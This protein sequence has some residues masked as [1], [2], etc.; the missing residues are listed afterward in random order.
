MARAEDIPVNGPA[1]DRRWRL[2]LLVALVAVVTGFYWHVIKAPDQVILNSTGD[3]LKN[4]YTLLWQANN[5]TSLLRYSGSNYPFGESVFYT[6]GHPLL[7]WLLRPL[8]G[9]AAQGVGVLNLLLFLGLLACCQCLYLLLRELG[10]APW[11]AAIG[12]FCITLLQPQIFRL[13]GHFS[14]A[15][16][17]IIPLLML[18]SVRLHTAERWRRPWSWTI[19]V[20][21]IAYLT[22]AYMGFMGTMLLLAHGFSRYVLGAF[23][24]RALRAFLFRTLPAAILPMLVFL[25]L[26]RMSDTVADRPAD[27]MG[28]DRYATRFLSLIVPTHD[29]FETPLR[30]FF[31]Y[32]KLEWEAWCYLGLSP[33]LVLVA[34]GAVQLRRWSVKGPRTPV[35]GAGQLLMAGFLVLLFA[36][37]VWQDWLGGG[38]PVLDQFRSTGRFAWPFFYACAVFCVVRAYQWFVAGENVRK[39]VAIPVFIVVT[40]FMAVEGWAYHRDGSGALGQA[41]NPFRE[42]GINDDRRAL[43]AAIKGSGAAAIVPQPLV[44]FGSERYDTSAPEGILGLTLPLAYHAGVPMMA[45]FT[46]R[47][48]LG[49]TR[50]LFALLAPPYFPKTLR[51]YLPDS[52]RLLLIRQVGRTAPAEDAA[53]ARAR[54]LLEN[55]EG[56]IR[57]ITAGELLPDE[58]EERKRWYAALRDSLP[59][60]GPWRFS[61]RNHPAS[62]EAMA[63]VFHGPD[64]LSGRVNEWYD[65]IRVEPGQLD[66]ATMYELTFL[67]S[68]PHPRSVNVN[69]ILLHETAW[70]TE[71][72]WEDLRSVRGMPMQ[73]GD[74][75]AVASFAFRAEHPDRRYKFLF[76]GPEADSSV[77]MVRDVLLRPL[78]LDV[79]REGTWEG[80]PCVFLNG[81]PLNYEGGS[82]A[83]PSG[84]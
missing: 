58:R 1:A 63:H 84:N 28:V 13:G 27:P 83:P 72:K 55:A 62:Q 35:D 36:F 2:A 16:A 25:L 29:P 32:D 75:L 78:D 46:S 61:Q 7:G 71:G 70:G 79:W 53:W 54:P 77:Y 14:L 60:G 73:L 52:T 12:A 5:D 9:L 24:R 11:A 56:S 17:W 68:T 48:S 49:Q 38:L 31:R 43:I 59:V 10:P 40:G 3:G 45:G 23:D 66:T 69:T 65:L 64:S 37:G 81:F 42:D 26:L 8:P 57:I 19:A 6:D 67:Y 15:H 51:Q 20:L 82:A 39:A 41:G 30:E 50:Q 21:L 4:Y 22:H 34:A 47:T 33:I 18:L 76:N 80:R 44:H 74:G